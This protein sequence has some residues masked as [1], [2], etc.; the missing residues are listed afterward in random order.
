VPVQR[1]AAGKLTAAE[2]PTQD[3]AHLRVRLRESLKEA[4]S[5]RDA[6]ATAALRSAISAIANAEAVDRS[7]EPPPTKATGNVRLGAGAAEVARRE[8]SGEDIL[9][10]VGAEVTERAAA[11]TEYERLGRTDQAL[12]LKAE[13]AVL[14]SFLDSTRRG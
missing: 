6:V 5:A 10:V 3:P 2:V 4:L 13:A 9:A 1:G 8:M 7:H 11:A 14:Q 12:R